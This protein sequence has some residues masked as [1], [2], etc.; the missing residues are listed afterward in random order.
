LHIFRGKFAYEKYDPLTLSFVCFAFLTAV[1]A[2]IC[3]SQ[4]YKVLSLA[5]F[6]IF[7]SKLGLICI[8][9]AN[10]LKIC[11]LSQ[12]F[13]PLTLRAGGNSFRG[14]DGEKVNWEADQ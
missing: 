8:K 10:Y 2:L 12:K 1:F 9:H 6:E 11:K 5:T 7:G 4:Q 13:N 14:R 3:D